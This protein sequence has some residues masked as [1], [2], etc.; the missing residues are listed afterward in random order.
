MT[1]T[2]LILPPRGLHITHKTVLGFFILLIVTSLFGVLIMNYLKIEGTNAE[3][4]KKISEYS[5]KPVSAIVTPVPGQVSDTSLIPVDEAEV[6]AL[7]DKVQSMVVVPEDEAPTLATVV[8][9]TELRKQPF[10]KNAVIDDK[11]FVYQQ[12]RLA[13]LFR[14]SVEKLVNMATLFDGSTGATPAAGAAQQVQG[15]TTQK[16]AEALQ[17]HRIAVYYATDSAALRTQISD[18]LSTMS[19]TKLAVE[20]LTR[21]TEYKGV[22]VIDLK[23]SQDELVQELVEKLDGRQGDMPEEE[24]TPDADI[25]LI[26]GE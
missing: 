25:L 9:V 20:A 3:L 18:A 6:Q 2:Q 22:T 14:P 13:I 8:E 10:F 26:V 4:A 16:Q 23:G 11:L 7:L 17:Q 21:G 19:D 12:S 15:V 24:D 5:T 1:H